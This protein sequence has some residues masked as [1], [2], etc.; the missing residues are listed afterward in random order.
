MLNVNTISNCFSLGD[1][2]S[3][4]MSLMAVHSSDEEEVKP[5][6][7]Q[8]GKRGPRANKKPPSAGS[9]DKGKI[10]GGKENDPQ[11][12]AVVK[13]EKKRKREEKQTG[14]KQKKKKSKCRYG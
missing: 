11:P 10:L 7:R 2:R 6:G 5:K 4:D 9:A 13:K 12:V 3:L 14:K 8:P 1:R